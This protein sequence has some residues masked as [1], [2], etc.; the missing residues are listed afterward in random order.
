MLHRVDR[1]REYESNVSARVFSALMRA[2]WNTDW[3]GVY[4]AGSDGPSEVMNRV[5]VKHAV[6]ASGR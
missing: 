1:T 3:T 2:D 6:T 5:L 4:M